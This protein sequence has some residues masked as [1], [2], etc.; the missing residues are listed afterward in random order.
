MFGTKGGTS[1][2]G[3][4]ACWGPKRIAIV[5]E[6]GLVAGAEGPLLVPLSAAASAAA[7]RAGGSLSTIY[8]EDDSGYESYYPFQFLKLS[9]SAFG[10]SF[11]WST[12]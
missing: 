8:K 11:V 12:A 2:G 5:Q 9:G 7:S 1:R 10:F 6:P 3:R 4:S